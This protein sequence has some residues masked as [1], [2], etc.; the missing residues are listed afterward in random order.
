MIVTGLM[1]V[2]EGIEGDRARHCLEFT[3]GNG[4]F[5]SSRIVLA[6]ILDTLQQDVGGVISQR[7][8]GIRYLGVTLVIL[9]CIAVALTKV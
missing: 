1:G 3:L 7:G 9:V 6:G 8:Q 5:Y 2:W 4:V